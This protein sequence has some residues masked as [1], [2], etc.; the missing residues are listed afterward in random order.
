[1][2]RH[3]RIHFVS[4]RSSL[5]NLPISLYG[6]LLERN[7][8]PQ[9]VAVVLSRLGVQK[10]DIYVGWTGMLAASSV[11]RFSGPTSGRGE[12]AMETV[13]MDPQ[14]ATG[15]GLAIG[16]VVEIGLAHDLPH[17]KTVM[18]E[19]L[20]PDDWEILELHAE[21][22]ES[23]LLSQV[24]AAAAGQEVNVWVHGATRVRLRVT[25]VDPTVRAVLLTTD[26]EIAIAPK[27]RRPPPASSKATLSPDAPAFASGAFKT[28]SSSKMA[29]SN[30]RTKIHSAILRVLP[31]SLVDNLPEAGE[32]PL[33][34][35]PVNMLI[36]ADLG[37][38]PYTAHILRLKP[39]A[40]PED[41]PNLQGSASAETKVLD[42]TKGGK[43]SDVE[44]AGGK[45][46]EEVEVMG[47]GS[48]PEGQVV[49]V[50]GAREPG[51]VKEW[52]LVR[53][54]S[55][56]ICASSSQTKP[57]APVLVR[58]T[59]APVHTLAGIDEILKSCG[60]F[61]R[62]AFVLYKSERVR[63]G[64]Q[65]LLVTG[66]TGAGK[67][68][69]CK[70]VARGLQVD[71]E[72]YAF[73]R[74]IDLARYK[75]KPVRVLRE[76]FTYWRDKA[77]WHRPSVLV[78]DNLDSVVPAEVEHVDSFR[79][80]HAA[81][82]FISIFARAC[83]VVL[84]ATAQNQQTLHPSLNTAHV[85]K[86]VV[87]LRPPDRDARKQILDLVLDTRLAAAEDLIFDPEHP[88][89]IVALATE[90][91]GYSATDLQDFVARAIHQ[92]AMRTAKHLDRDD[93]IQTTLSMEDFKKTKEGFMPLS[94][95]DVPLQT[96]TVKW[97]DIGGLN[98]T[99]RILRETLEWPTKYAP[100]F[101]Q[102]PLRLRS[103][104]LLYGYPG[105]GKTLLA[106]AV[107][108]ECGLNFISV[109][110]PELLNKY[111][112]ASEKSVR[113]IFERASAAKPCVLFFDEFDSIAPKRGHDS[114]GV[115]DRVVNQLLTLM[116]GAEGLDGVYVLAAT[117]RP[118][119][120]D[121]ALLRPG[122]LD[123]SLLCNMPSLAERAEILAAHARKL[124]VSSTVNFV[125]I[126]ERTD[127]F[128][129]ADLQ[130][131]VYNAHLEAVHSDL[132]MHASLADDPQTESGEEK[133]VKFV[134]FGGEEGE[135]IRSRAEEMALQRRILQLMTAAADPGSREG[136]RPPCMPFFGFANSAQH[137]IT[138]AHLA[139]ALANAR[140]SVSAE[141]VARLSRIYAAFVS[142]RSGELP[143]PPDAGGVGKRATL[144]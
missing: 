71:P 48:V 136:A 123:K 46:A 6:P 9:H 106:S 50:G 139:R 142:D 128:S 84:L 12:G 125:F 114:T 118:D 76:L 86:K 138:D 79:F 35:V 61:C 69:I 31:A 78:L 11:A 101:K 16:D 53:C 19:P 13:E 73:S 97:S 39:P 131:L 14:F 54:V 77:A 1:M 25:D 133:Q 41:V 104:L 43:T 141:E 134:T 126:A 102:S 24:R 99:R 81:E 89:N 4:L 45:D 116:D 92:A 74:Y 109:K 137:E 59:R 112:G 32:D 75:D 58:P 140:P 49:V 91:E 121:S 36:R 130:A 144:M 93:T 33:L 117:S 124:P 10:Q 38:G 8:R 85:F 22:V 34:C 21:H 2:P 108:R 30:S 87:A 28:A 72:V 26:T 65:C 120:I 40:D 27:T 37:P 90:T 110:G 135:G 127:G 64:V 103:G 96:S 7:V 15:L 5:V 67:T 98:E 83:G 44:S 57:S 3:V 29:L 56:F 42:L 95:R 143:V 113:D 66:R 105:C 100:I 82:S 55:L 80:R 23:T 68:E 111:I 52:D 63:P 70:A 20:T 62:A 18:A 129:G 60:D 132:G 88:P 107:A 122:R 119:L 94:L 47:C 51:E 115:T 17:A